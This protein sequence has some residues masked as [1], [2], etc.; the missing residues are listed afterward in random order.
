M[1]FARIYLMFIA[2]MS[3]VFG[4]IYF[5]SPAVMTDPTGFG[6][7]APAA[8]T[9]VRATYGGFQLGS[10][11]FLLWS[12]AQPQ[13][14]RPALLL[15]AL[16]FAGVLVCRGIGM[17]IDGSATS[18]LVNALITEAV[19]TALALVALA[20]TPAPARAGARPA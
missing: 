3:L 7:L 5:I 19:L 16:T 8:V 1:S 12:A 4:A 17:L 2:A 20:R 6:L 11:L 18:F 9:D 14:I 15:V 10:G 13:R